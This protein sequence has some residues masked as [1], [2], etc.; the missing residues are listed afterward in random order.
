M[1]FEREGKRLL[2]EFEFPELFKYDERDDEGACHYRQKRLEIPLQ[3]DERERQ[4]DDKH[5]GADGDKRRNACAHTR[6]D[7]VYICFEHKYAQVSPTQL[8]QREQYVGIT[9]VVF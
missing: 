1:E 8:L 3:G 6:S 5:R 2:S 7:V 9:Q 4:R